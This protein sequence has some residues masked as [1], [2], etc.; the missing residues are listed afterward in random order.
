[1]IIS[2]KKKSIS[3]FIPDFFFFKS[4]Q[5]R[6]KKELFEPDKGYLWETYKEH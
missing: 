3:T 6:N 2:K 4:Q 1:M 5:Y